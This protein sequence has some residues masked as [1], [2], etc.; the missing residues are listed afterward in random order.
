MESTVAV[1]K[2]FADSN[3]DLNVGTERVS[4]D[5]PRPYHSG[6]VSGAQP[7]LLFVRYEGKLFISG[8]TPTELFMSWD[9]CEDLAQQLL[10]KFQEGQGGQT[11]TYE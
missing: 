9:I 6:A 1:M 5:F 3:D 7:K 2:K 4:G 11:S 8:G 10:T